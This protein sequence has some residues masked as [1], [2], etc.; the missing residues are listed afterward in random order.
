MKLSWALSMVLSA[1]VAVTALAA[2]S[3]QHKSEGKR[4]QAG[5]GAHSAMPSPEQIM[6]KLDKNHDGSLSEE[7]F[8]ACPLAHDKERAKAIFHRIDANGDGKVTLEELKSA[9][10]KMAGARH[11]AEHRGPRPG[12]IGGPAAA[13]APKWPSADE[14]FKRMDADHDG[15]IS[16]AEFKVAFEHMQAMHKKAMENIHQRIAG[17]NHRPGFPGAHAPYHAPFHAGP[18]HHGKPGPHGSSCHHGKPGQHA[19]T[20]H[21]GKP[22]QHG[23]SSCHCQKSHHGQ[24]G[25]PSGHG[26]K[27]H[28]GHHAHHGKPSSH[29]AHHGKPSSHHGHHGKPSCPHHAPPHRHPGPAAHGCPMGP[30]CPAYHRGPAGHGGPGSHAFGPRPHGMPPFDH[31]SHDGIRPHAGPQGGPGSFSHREGA[32]CPDGK[33]PFAGPAKPQ[34]DFHGFRGPAE[35]GFRGPA[36]HG[37]RGPGGDGH[38]GDHPDGK[39]GP[40]PEKKPGPGPEKKHGPGLEKKPGPGPEKKHDPRSEKKDA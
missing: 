21:H 33:C 32:A 22:S 39:H 25:K 10:A 35:H 40:G 16:P 1:S 11:I 23:K 17:S 15:K 5:P 18:M 9:H 8:L 2:D 7:E 12:M 19:G 24:H 6:Q 20:C 29:H 30:G 26:K 37:F 4:L 34:G 31:R 28:A 13:G 27:G 3:V 38:H 36:E 14:A